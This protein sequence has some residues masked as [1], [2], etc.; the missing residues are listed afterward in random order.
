M[1]YIVRSKGTGMVLVRG[2]DEWEFYWSKNLQD[3]TQFATRQE[4]A[5]YIQP[6]GCLWRTEILFVDWKD[7]PTVPAST[8]NMKLSDLP[9][10]KKFKGVFIHPTITFMK[11]VQPTDGLNTK[12]VIVID[13]LKDSNDPLT[14][15]RIISLNSDT[16]VREVQ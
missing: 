7:D 11:I 12:W 3:A 6:T 1:A 14:V 16:L 5:D 13:N 15:G 8:D 9:E 10:G 2:K 4:A